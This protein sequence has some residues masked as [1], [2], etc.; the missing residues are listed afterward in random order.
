MF[1]VMSGTIHFRQFIASAKLMG[2]VTGNI[3]IIKKLMIDSLDCQVTNGPKCYYLLHPN[4]VVC[5]SPLCTCYLV[6]TSYITG[7]AV[8]ITR[9]SIRLLL[10][11]EPL[12]HHNPVSFSFSFIL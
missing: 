4:Q 8:A 9:V 10:N 11:S 6:H 7:I 3:C 2:N 1:Y 12:D 5:N